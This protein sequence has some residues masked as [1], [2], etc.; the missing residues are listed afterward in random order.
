MSLGNRKHIIFDVFCDHV[1]GF[2]RV[3]FHSA[4]AQSL[5]LAQGIEVNP[6]VFPYVRTVDAAHRA[7][8]YGEVMTE[9]VAE[10]AFTDKTDS[11]A[12]FFIVGGQPVFF[13]Q[14]A[15][16]RLF[17]GAQREQALS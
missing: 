10:R 11:G 15:H 12:V 16:L 1:P 2:F 13:C 14:G 9:K 8:L 4:D 17:Q 6:R 7:G 5:A 3:T